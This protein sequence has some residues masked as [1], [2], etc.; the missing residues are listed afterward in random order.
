MNAMHASESAT[1]W[2]RSDGA[3]DVSAR[4]PAATETATVRT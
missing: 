2:P 3:A 4:I 1:S